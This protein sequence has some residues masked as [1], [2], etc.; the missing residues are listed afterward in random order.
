MCIHCLTSQAIRP[1]L[2]QKDYSL[3]KTSK[4]RTVL[5]KYQQVLKRFFSKRE[6]KNGW[7]LCKFA[8][9]KHI[10]RP[11]HGNLLIKLTSWCRSNRHVSVDRMAFNPKNHIRALKRCSKRERNNCWLLRKFASA[12]HIPCQN[13]GPIHCILMSNI[14]TYIC[15]VNTFFVAYQQHFLRSLP[16]NCHAL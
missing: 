5:C 3:L 13:C 14:T 1:Q 6:R 7:R 4:H 10:P 12:K 11:I 9:A 15:I 16:T 8:A 2:L